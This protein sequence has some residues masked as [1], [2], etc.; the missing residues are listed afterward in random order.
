MTRLIGVDH[1][2]TLIAPSEPRRLYWQ[3]GRTNDAITIEE[4]VV[5]T[6]NG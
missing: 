4:R 2:A 1:P 5:E 3:A 6:M